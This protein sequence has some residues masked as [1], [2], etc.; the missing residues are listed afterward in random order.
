LCGFSGRAF[1]SYF[2][3]FSGTDA[4]GAIA[5]RTKQF[6]EGNLFERQFETRI[7]LE[8]IRV[9]ETVG[10]ALQARGQ[11]KRCGR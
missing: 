8:N 5:L 1:A 7:R 10:G 11:V 2:R 3:T 4:S 9:V 6:R